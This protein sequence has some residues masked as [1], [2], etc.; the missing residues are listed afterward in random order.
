MTSTKDRWLAD[1]IGTLRSYWRVGAVRLK[2][3]SG[4]LQVR[5]S[6][7]SADANLKAAAIQLS[8][9]PG[10]GK[11]LT[12]DASGNGSWSDVPGAVDSVL[13]DYIMLDSLQQH[14]VT[15]SALVV[16]LSTTYQNNHAVVNS[17][18]ANGDSWELH[19]VCAAGVYNLRIVGSTNTNAPKLDV[20]IDGVLQANIDWYSNPGVV[21]VTKSLFTGALTSGLHTL[22]CTVNGKNASSSGYALAVNYYLLNP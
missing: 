6:G 22:T 11:V 10:A 2:D 4:V 17:P 1:A 7:D 18:G 13:P 21:N 15:G 14:Y 12:S 9:S 5:N 16:G 19:F 3:V 8:T 20:F